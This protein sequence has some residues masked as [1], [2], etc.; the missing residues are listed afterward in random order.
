MK[1]KLK[2]NKIVNVS[3]RILPIILLTSTLLTNTACR[4][5][6]KPEVTQ[7][8][9]VEIPQYRDLSV[10]RNVNLPT[11]KDKFKGETYTFVK[12][13]DVF[14]YCV[15]LKYAIKDYFKKY[16]ASDWY[17]PEEQK[18]WMDNVEYVV[19]AIAYAEST[20]RTDCF[21]ERGCGGITGLNKQQVLET[22]D[23]W[24]HE[25]A[26]WGKNF[27]DISTEDENVDVFNPATS[28]EYTYYNIGY[29]SR[30]IFQK[31]KKFE[32]NGE[33]YCIWDNIAFS[34]ENQN[35]LIIAS[36]LFGIGNIVDASKGVQK[37]GHNIDYYLNSK[38]V[39]KVLDKTEELKSKYISEFN[40]QELV[41]YSR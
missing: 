26:V 6:I 35:K 24:L 23:N 36:H 30:V 28:L 32:Y 1:N 15:E 12:E 40:L 29:V 8:V 14:A 7:K 2:S 20:Y 13:K 27:P 25:T 18:F 16:G 5:N 9:Y 4:D 10:L 17:S 21:N 11:Y 31:D 34:R 41:E 33:M 19:T 22:L 38:Y 39:Q 37:D 3:K